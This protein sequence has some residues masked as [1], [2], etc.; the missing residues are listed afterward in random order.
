MPFANPS[1]LTHDLAAVFNEAKSASGRAEILAA[2]IGSPLATASIHR[3][4]LGFLVAKAECGVGTALRLHFWSKK[5]KALQSG[6]EVHD[7]GFDL[8]SLVITG[9]VQQT[10]YEAVDDRDGA[11]RVY[12]VEYSGKASVLEASSRL[13]R[14]SIIREERFAEGQTYTLPAR[15]LHQLECVADEAVTLVLT[16]TQRELPVT[17]GPKDAAVEL[18]S[19]RT[20]LLDAHGS[21][22]TLAGS[23]ELRSMLLGAQPTAD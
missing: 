20:P 2:L 10:V 12:T 5:W 23:K 7:H 9:H 6:F 1:P 13:V 19:P 4:P 17:L 11:N 3:H 8:E 21:L 22:L 14:L 15:V 16:H 18:Q